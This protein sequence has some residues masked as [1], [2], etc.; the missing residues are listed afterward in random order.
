MTTFIVHLPATDF[1]RLS[2]FNHESVEQVSVPQLVSL[3]PDRRITLVRASFR[4]V[5]K[6]SKM[7]P[8]WRFQAL[9][10]C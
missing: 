3:R 2:M 9:I 7:F 6:L 1:H 10:G 8:D 4:T 5:G